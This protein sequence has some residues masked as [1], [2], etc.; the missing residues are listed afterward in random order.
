MSL[1]AVYDL[2]QNVALHLNYSN[3]SNAVASG[4]GSSL[5]TFMLEAAW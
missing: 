1:F 3:Y 5:T 4:H 2:A